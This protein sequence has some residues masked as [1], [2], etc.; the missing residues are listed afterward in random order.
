M[1]KWQGY[2]HLD[3]IHGMKN[4][5]RELLGKTIFLQEKRD[6]ENVSISFETVPPTSF[7]SE[8]SDG[9]VIIWN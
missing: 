5:G 3:R 2:P 1:T 7:E 6:G 4:E 9:L 8:P